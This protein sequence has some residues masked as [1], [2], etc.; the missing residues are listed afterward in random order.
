[1]PRRECITCRV[2]HAN[3]GPRCPTCARTQQRQR[4]TIR[5]TAAQRGY[6]AQWR[7]LSARVIAYY[8]QCLDCGHTGSRDN[9]LT[10]DHIIPKAKGGT[11]DWP[12]LCCRCRVH[13]SA[14]GAR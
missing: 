4:D 2:L 1:M 7:A 3:S 6:D 5:G 11:D 14:K 13:N 9:P 12:N 8:K 10:A